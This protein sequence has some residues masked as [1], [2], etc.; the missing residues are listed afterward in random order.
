M[1]SEWR[2][3]A[4]LFQGC[5]LFYHVCIRRIEAAQTHMNDTLHLTMPLSPDHTHIKTSSTYSV[6]TTLRTGSSTWVMLD[7][8]RSS[9]ILLCSTSS[10][11]RDVSAT[12]LSAHAHTHKYIHTQFVSTHAGTLTSQAVPPGKKIDYERNHKGRS[13]IIWWL[14][15][16]VTW[17]IRVCFLHSPSNT[18]TPTCKSV[19]LMTRTKRIM[20]TLDP[21]KR[22][23]LCP[24]KTLTPLRWCHTILNSCPQKT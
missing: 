6:A 2:Q 1:W 14:R 21:I 20:N 9:S 5:P 4:S 15:S 8:W 10:F 7:I 23:P 24:A 11:S 22:H 3:V 19:Q 17:R 16:S 13:S 12:K 18:A